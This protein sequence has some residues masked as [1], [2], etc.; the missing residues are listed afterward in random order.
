MIINYLN[1]LASVELTCSW[2]RLV[3]NDTTTATNNNSI[4][5][6]VS[7]E[8]ATT[9]N[10]HFH[11]I[12]TSMRAVPIRCSDVYCLSPNEAEAFYEIYILHELL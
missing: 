2:P 8:P 7:N 6:L 5:R 1:A 3:D 4:R 9:A 10:M 11:R 12:C